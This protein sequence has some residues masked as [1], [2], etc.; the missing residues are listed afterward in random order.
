MA[1]T[2]GPGRFPGEGHGNPR[3]YP[4]LGHLIRQRSLAGTDLNVARGQTQLKRLSPHSASRRRSR[5]FCAPSSK[6][7]LASGGHRGYGRAQRME[8]NLG[9]PG[10]RPL[11]EALVSRH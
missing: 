6:V 7:G 5:K 10:H 1:L 2:P 4:C 11:S 3:Q 9:E 8:G